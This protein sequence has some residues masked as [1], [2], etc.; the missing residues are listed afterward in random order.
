MYICLHNGNSAVHCFIVKVIQKRAATVEQ[1]ERA[2]KEM[3][4]LGARVQ[5]LRR[6]V[7]NAKVPAHKLLTG[8]DIKEFCR[9]TNLTLDIFTRLVGT[10]RR[11]VATWLSGNP[12]S[13]ANERNLIELSR[14]FAA[15]VELV[16]TSQIGSWLET[17]N[18][19]FEG[20]TPVQVI[21]RG[22]SDRIW[23]MIWEL[24]GGN[25]GD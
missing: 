19:A 6:Q 1:L 12:P 14:L 23:R 8:A 11:A 13:R 3:A 7:K 15:L 9:Q 2:E 21:E 16:P 25:S 5:K 10:S 18:S 22:E 24:R 20:S 17:S 4:H